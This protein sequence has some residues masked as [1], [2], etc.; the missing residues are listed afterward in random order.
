MGKLTIS[1]CGNLSQV[2]PVTSG[3]VQA[4][5]AEGAIAPPNNVQNVLKTIHKVALLL[6]FSMFSPPRTF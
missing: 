2:R 4:G 3:T 5:L 1:S 6:I